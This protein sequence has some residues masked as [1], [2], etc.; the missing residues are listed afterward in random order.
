MEKLECS[1]KSAIN[2]FEYN[3][4]KL[5]SKKCHL[6][7]CGHKFESM[8]CNIGNAQVIETG[9]VR[10]LGISIDSELSFE[11][12]MNSILQDLKQLFEDDTL[13]ILFCMI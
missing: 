5:N 10:L 12:H 13:L 8:I 2:W 9:Q 11:N 7:V 6:L 4:M 1:V 3:G